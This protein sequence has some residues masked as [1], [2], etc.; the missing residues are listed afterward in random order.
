MVFKILMT[1][2]K[3]NSFSLIPSIF[4]R[5]KLDDN[6]F[7]VHHKGYQYWRIIYLLAHLYN[8]QSLIQKLTSVT[9][10]AVSKTEV[11]S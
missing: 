3:F 6:R 7:Q 5:F 2:K 11:V 10:A 4:L 8:S 1:K 9:T